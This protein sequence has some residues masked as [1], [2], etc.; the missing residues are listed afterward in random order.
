M[1]IPDSM[2]CRTQMLIQSLFQQFVGSGGVREISES[3]VPY[4]RKRSGGDAGR[5]VSQ[6]SISYK[7]SP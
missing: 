2:L 1:S 6:T 3:R 7:R 4:T 5:S